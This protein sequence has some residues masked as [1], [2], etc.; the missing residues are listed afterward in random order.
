MKYDLLLSI[1]PIE[2]LIKI[3]VDTD[4]NIAFTRFT[5]TI[6]QGL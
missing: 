6:N 4:K 3:T 2:N 5:L 1:R